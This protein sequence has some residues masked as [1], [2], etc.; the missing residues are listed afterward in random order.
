[1]K[2]IGA[3]IGSAL[4]EL[5]VH[6]NTIEASVARRALT[7]QNAVNRSLDLLLEYRSR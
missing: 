4:R 7:T 5:I 3:R 1:M 2:T 6:R